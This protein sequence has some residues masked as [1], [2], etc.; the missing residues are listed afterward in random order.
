M[1][2][3]KQEERKWKLVVIEAIFWELVAMKDRKIGIFVV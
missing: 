1:M 3:L 2:A